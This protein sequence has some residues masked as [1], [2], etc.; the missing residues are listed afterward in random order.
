MPDL[1]KYKGPFQTVINIDGDSNEKV[2]GA[3]LDWQGAREIADYYAGRDH[4]QSVLIRDEPSQQTV[5]VAYCRDPH[6]NADSGEQSEG[7]PAPVV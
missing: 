2:V 7:D 1:Q 6:E 3:G 4:V 5:E